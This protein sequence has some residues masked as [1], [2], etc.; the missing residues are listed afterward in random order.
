MTQVEDGMYVS[1]A[2]KGTLEN[3][4]VFD[5]TSDQSGPMEFQ[6]GS[7]QLIQGFEAAVMGM[8]VDEKKT[9]TLEP[10]EAYGPRDENLTRDFPR[11]SIPSEIDPQ[12]GMI[13]GLKSQEGKQIPAVISHVD[14]EKITLDI[15]HP[16]AG[17]TLTFDIQVK[18]I[19]DTPTQGK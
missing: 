13:I 7:G 15:N 18:G 12:V 8:A 2:Y 3:G 5:E 10:E 17:K 16:L 4:E 6:M 19:S 9:V 11:T 14:Q 1:V